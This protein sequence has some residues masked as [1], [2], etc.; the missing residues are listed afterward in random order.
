MTKHRHLR[1]SGTSESLNVAQGH[2]RQSDLALSAGDSADALC[3]L[4]PLNLLA[5]SDNSSNSRC[6]CGHGP[7]GFEGSL[8]LF[9]PNGYP[10]QPSFPLRLV[11][12]GA[13]LGFNPGLSRS[14]AA[15]SCSHLAA[16]A[17]S[18]GKCKGKALWPRIFVALLSCPGG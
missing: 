8:K 4:G 2:S 1:A 9:S 11:Y 15:L 12:V 17:S 14:S 18:V 6:S 5:A 16:R 7:L 3:F 10:C 13:S